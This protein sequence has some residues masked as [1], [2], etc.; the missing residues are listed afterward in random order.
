MTRGQY[1]LLLFASY[2]QCP[3]FVS[4]PYSLGA[5]R[6]TGPVRSSVKVGWLDKYGYLTSGNEMSSM[7]KGKANGLNSHTPSSGNAAA[8]S[9]TLASGVV[10]ARAG[11]YLSEPCRSDMRTTNDGNHQPNPH[12][13][14]HNVADY[15]QRLHTN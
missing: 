4:A 11:H 5:L 14:S 8:W 3:S 6:L 1:G 15:T 9:P 7:A 12:D 13:G 2:W 10:S